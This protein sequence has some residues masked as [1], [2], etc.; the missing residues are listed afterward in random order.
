MPK[1]IQKPH[2]P[3]WLAGTAPESFEI[4]GDNGMGALTFA[5][6]EDAIVNNLET[7]RKSI[8]K[9][10][11]PK[12]NFINNKYAAFC[13]PLVGADPETQT[14]GVEGAQWFLQKVTEI[15]LTMDKI[16]S[17]SYSY[18]KQTI[19]LNNLQ[20]DTPLSVLN[21]HPL[22]ICGGV[23]YSIR[24]I[25]NLVDIGIDQLICFMQR[26]RIPH[27]R[28][29]ETID[30]FGKYILPHFRERNPS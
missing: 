9:C 11:K 29:M 8:A 22:I 2:P 21:E 16:E 27:S 12:G 30:N 7:Y 24:K 20:K 26:G 17:E 19:D 10:T 14:I 6:T 28:I 23:D 4:A 3:I 13:L 15:L 18:L 5:F 1:P 25:E